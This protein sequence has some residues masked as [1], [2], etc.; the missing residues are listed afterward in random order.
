M[1]YS[2]AD[3]LNTFKS[4]SELVDYT[5]GDKRKEVRSSL[6][7]ES[8]NT[9][10]FLCPKCNKFSYILYCLDGR[11]SCLMC[12]GINISKGRH[13]IFWAY[14]LTNDIVEFFGGEDGGVEAT[15]LF[16]K[17]LLDSFVFY[18]GLDPKVDQA[19]YLYFLEFI[20]EVVKKEYE[21]LGVLGFIESS[22]KK[23]TKKNG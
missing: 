4:I 17:E 10:R 14:M 18:I 15:T 12:H 22:R 13:R 19:K 8:K 23:I 3:I 9:R 21:G 6:M 7:K 20:Q 16:N 5:E 1:R 11:V 2:K